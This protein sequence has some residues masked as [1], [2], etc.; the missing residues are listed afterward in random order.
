MKTTLYC[1]FYA[2]RF[3]GRE[4]TYELYSMLHIWKLW[5]LG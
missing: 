2:W 1:Y 5:T 4:F 3:E